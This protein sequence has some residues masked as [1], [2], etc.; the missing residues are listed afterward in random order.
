MIERDPYDN[1]NTQRVIAAKAPEPFKPSP[2]DVVEW[3]PPPENVE[4][5]GTDLE[6]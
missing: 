6:G 1:G 2:Q 5:A 4:L 3:S